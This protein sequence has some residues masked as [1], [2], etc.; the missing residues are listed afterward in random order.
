VFAVD[1]G[2]PGRFRTIFDTEA[3][4]VTLVANASE[5]DLAA[6]DVHTIDAGPV[7]P[8]R[9]LY[10]GLIA[11]GIETY[12]VGDCDG[13]PAEGVGGIEAAFAA[14]GRLVERLRVASR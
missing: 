9:D 10:D 8:Q 13:P 14:V 1:M 12:A 2:L 4:G 6:I 11:A 7:R 3:A 5:A